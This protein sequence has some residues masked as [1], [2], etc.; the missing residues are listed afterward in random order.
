VARF[1][2][3]RGIGGRQ[4]EKITGCMDELGDLDVLQYLLRWSP[5]SLRFLAK[6]LDA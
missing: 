1:F 5:R 4:I 2:D 3:L 6:S